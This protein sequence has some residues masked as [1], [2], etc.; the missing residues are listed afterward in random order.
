MSTKTISRE[1]VLNLLEYKEGVLYW[2]TSRQGVKKNR[3]AGSTIAGGYRHISINGVY[4]YVHRL[5]FLI[6][7]GFIPEKVDHIN[8]I[9]NDNR[10]ENLR[11]A[12][13]SQ[14]LWNM[15]IRSSNK[16]GVKGVF[17]CNTKKKWVAKF[18]MYYKAYYA[19]S[20]NTIEEA[21][22]AIIKKREILHKEFARHE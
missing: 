12:T 3:L 1:E 22:E 4:F 21:E 16:S 14:N 18:N 19:G 11:A 15:K 10:I 6:H 17:F 7:H 13:Q 2:K 8:G 20:F 5:V 9:R